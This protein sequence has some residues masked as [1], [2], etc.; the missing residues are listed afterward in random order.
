MKKYVL[1]HLIAWL[2]RK[3]LSFYLLIGILLAMNV[4][5]FSQAT[6]Y[7]AK[8]DAFIKIHFKGISNACI[9]PWATTKS[10]YIDNVFYK[11]YT[12]TSSSLIHFDTPGITHTLYFKV[13]YTG[14]LCD[15]TLTSPTV[16]VTL[17]DLLP[18]TDLVATDN[19][20]AKAIELTWGRG[21]YFPVEDISYYIY[22][23]DAQIATVA[24]T[25]RSNDIYTFTDKNRKAGEKNTYT[26]KT[27]LKTK[28]IF[29]K[30]V[31]VQGS[32]F[33]I[34]LQASTNKTGKVQLSWANASVTGATGYKLYRSDGTINPNIY[35]ANSAEYLYYQDD[36][37][38]TPGY[39]YTYTITANST[40]DVTQSVQGR[41]LPNGTISGKVTAP[42]GGPIGNVKIMA[43]RQ[44]TVAGDTT[45]VYYAYT[46]PNDGT[47]AINYVFYNEK[48][49]FKVSPILEN[50]G[51]NPDYKNISLL[52][53]N[54]IQTEINF[55]DT[56]AFTVSGSIIQQGKQSACPIAK[57]EI[58]VDSLFKG[59]K[60]DKSGNYSLTVPQS[61]N[62]TITARM[63]NHLFN[64]PNIKILITDNTSQINF[65]D[66]TKFLLQGYFTASCN[67]YIGR[68]TLRFYSADG[69]N[70]MIDTLTTNSDSGYFK[71]ELPARKYKV[72][73]L[74]FTSVDENLIAAADVEAY[75]SASRTIDLTTGKAQLNYTYRLK[76]ELSISGL[77]DETTTCDSTPILQ[78]NKSYP[79][80]FNIN[81]SFGGQ[82][83]P[84]DTGYITFE[85]D[86]ADG[87]LKTDTLYFKNGKDSINLTPGEPNTIADY[88]RNLNATV[89]VGEKNSNFNSKVLVVGY[90]P[91][92]KTF[93]TV[94]PAIPFLIVHDPP[95]DGSYSTFEKSTSINQSIS[96]S[97]EFSGSVNTW[98]K[99]KLG[100][101]F[102]AGE[103]VS[104]ETS[105]WGE[106]GIAL[107]AG[108]SSVN[109]EELNLSITATK[110]Y[111]TSS[112]DDIIGDGGDV[113]IGGALN[114]IY[115]LT[116][117]IAYDA[118]SCKV[119]KYN[120][121]IVVPD[122]FKTT[123]MY[124]ENHITN[125]LI[126]QLEQIRDT[127][128]SKGNDSAEIYTNQIKVWEQV[129]SSNHE[130]I[131]KANKIENISFSAGN[132]YSS[133]LESS[134]SSTS[135]LDF[136]MY[137]DASVAVEAGLE[138]GGSGTSAGVEAHF[139][140][141]HG[142][143]QSTTTSK[144]HTTG[145]ALS[146]DD[147][148][149]YF[150]VD[151]LNDK[152]YGTPAF[153]LVA[154]RSSCPWESGTQRRDDLQF[155]SDTYSQTVSDANGQAV[156][157]L[158]LGN[159]S[160]SNEDRTYNLIFDQTSNPNGALITIGGSPVVGNVPIP[161][162]IPAG[163]AVYATVTIQKGPN[164]S[165]Y[166]D[167]KF[168]LESACD[169]QIAED[170]YLNA[171]FPSSCSSI[172]IATK[173][174]HPVINQASGNNLNFS[175]SD[176]DKSKMDNIEMQIRKQGE[177]FW[178]SYQNISVSQL[179]DN[180]STDIVFTL[181]TLAD[182]DYEFRATLQ[183]SDDVIASNTV[184][185]T[186]D[187]ISP[188][189]SGVPQ[190]SSGS[191]QEGDNISVSFSENINCDAL[192]NSNIKIKNQ[193]TQIN[194]NDNYGCF[195]NKIII[196]P[197]D[198][199]DIKAGD[200]LQVQVSG[201]S[202]LVGNK[203]ADTIL[204]AFNIPN[205]DVLTN[206]S[207]GD[208]DNDGI[209]NDMDNCTLSFNP[210]QE[211]MDNDGIGDVCDPDIDGDEINNA[212]DNCPSFANTNQAD[213]DS[214]G[215]GDL[216]DDDID[217]DG[218]VNSLDNCPTTA[219]KDQVD[220]DNNG[221]GDA[222]DG[223]SGIKN[224]GFNPKGKNFIIYPNP[225]TKSTSFSVHL[226]RT[227]FV[228][229]TIYNLNGQKIQT[230]M[231]KKLQKGNHSIPFYAQ[232]IKPGIYF[233]KLTI[234][235][236]NYRA[237]IIKTK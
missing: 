228:K 20:F 124:T 46:D 159:I 89:Y 86:I 144:S 12:K 18:P 188:K 165:S 236:L 81:E 191:Y 75:F 175:F 21:T 9:A 116:E 233:S 127:Y 24:G 149:D 101:K 108:V 204:W 171:Y 234:G 114:M 110:A 90:K 178:T 202:D 47:Y 70:C 215:I 225:F 197:L 220:S 186:L 100:T 33:D 80:I 40:S 132:E 19:K 131:L 77:S 166:T 222:C 11:D 55:T 140:V 192:S 115:A 224:K 42:Y 13:R 79:I 5:A 219:N 211:D 195:E 134:S 217:G 130:N 147:A 111:S 60:T 67:I 31:S 163:K 23:N 148:G 56:S 43:V 49:S 104:V 38:L 229:I 206:D 152:V 156:F 183:C 26:I 176:Y 143:G 181:D 37:N 15:Y 36:A 214:D 68:A 14:F 48:S 167:L 173:K 61:D 4:S 150:S 182:S 232:K 185:I 10:L 158:Q 54:N 168:T 50:H 184:G 30:A 135:S 190:P 22:R 162:E 58:L 52:T 231:N 85:Q 138:I 189:L 112:N 71:I 213:K 123:Y 66:T 199:A 17:D 8:S 117:I 145:Y 91:K 41:T 154:G 107:E 109:S 96:F 6:L 139:K 64:P 203:Q 87:H 1:N 93:T 187:R 170:V 69:S 169:G 221:I 118:D 76:P 235:N 83:C 128:L 99:V 25:D 212:I 196:Q 103:I 122:G 194:I 32:T 72:D 201:I 136:S 198:L 51:F 164:V 155:T 97:T 200:S 177:I 98:A 126:P 102:E 205:R 57:V 172:I 179:N 92:G 193:T 226:L 29:S 39:Y 174:Q 208:Y 113:Y 137:V 74:S 2:K 129:V 223:I 125:V 84:A 34:H 62:Y 45:S 73:L 142:E 161:Y 35:E 63:K 207:A 218:I 16:S 160:Q 65:T 120:N 180:G 141:E 94:T 105:I 82:S 78:Q 28:K 27:Y 106:I 3:K 157:R 119:D 151:I 88:M 7:T 230:I 210:Y 227:E 53:S 44:D 121:I 95:G 237:K 153:K 209:L 146:D 133:S 216:C 59:T